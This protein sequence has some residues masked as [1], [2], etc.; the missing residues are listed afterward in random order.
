MA[1]RLILGVGGKC[2]GVHGHNEHVVVHAVPAGEFDMNQ[3]NM[4]MDFADA[5]GVWHQFIDNVVDHAFQLGNTDR[6]IDYFRINEPDK[7]P[8]LLVTHGDPTTEMLCMV[9]IRKFHALCGD[10]L[11]LRRLEI[12]ETPTNT[13]AF[14]VPVDA[15]KRTIYDFLNAPVDT[16]NWWDRPDMTINDITL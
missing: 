5:K 1:H 16:S 12:E 3:G 4:C 13:V 10:A 7:V 2:A 11:R 8:R 15:T 14:D 6:L 9:L